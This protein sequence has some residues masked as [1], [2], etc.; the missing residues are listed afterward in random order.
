MQVK[1]VNLEYQA[2]SW[3]RRHRVIHK[4]EWHAGN[5]FPRIGFIAMN[6]RLA[7][8]KEVKVYN[9]R[10]EIENRIK[11]VKN[12]LRWEKNSCTRFEANEARLKMGDLAYNLLHM[13]RKSYIRGEGVRRSIEWLILRLIKV[14]DRV[15]HHATN[16]YVHISTAFPLDNHFRAVFD[17]G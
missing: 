11:K 4:I 5:L 2:G 7:V 14:G 3:D 17:T 9:D 8:G 15:S 13:L 1:Y 10:T 16:R 12:G 6:S